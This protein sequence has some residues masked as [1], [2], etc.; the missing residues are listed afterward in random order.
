MLQQF[1]PPPAI[2]DYLEAPADG[3]ELPD[4]LNVLCENL[5]LRRGVVANGVGLRDLT[6]SPDSYGVQ[7]FAGENAS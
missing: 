6:R 5:E 4:Y 3:P 7:Y 2:Q 1:P